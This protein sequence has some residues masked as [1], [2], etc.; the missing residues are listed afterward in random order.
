MEPIYTVKLGVYN[1]C[2]TEGTQRDF[3]IEKVEIHEMY[4]VNTPYY[5]IALLTLVEDTN[6]YQPICLPKYGKFPNYDFFKY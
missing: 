1:I 3:K 4:Y 5:D 2:T 6:A